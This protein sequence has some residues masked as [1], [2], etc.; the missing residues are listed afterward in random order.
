MAL[1]KLN[2]TGQ[3]VVP[4]AKM[5]SGTIVQH[6]QLSNTGRGAQNSH[7]SNSF[8]HIGSKFDV[9]IT[10]K[11]QSSLILY[12]ASLSVHVANGGG[13]GYWELRRDIGGTE[14]S[15]GDDSSYG[16]TKIHD[17]LWLQCPLFYVDSPNTT[18]AVTYKIYSRANANGNNI[19]TGW[20]SGNDSK[21][22]GC[23]ISVLEIVG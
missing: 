23:Y 13:Y 12:N 21:A 9:T 7:N 14:T 17:A 1:T 2:Y 8:T 5:P 10:P 20:A 22:N 4:H 18:S 3:G 11:F 6:V 15:F 19:Y 16:N